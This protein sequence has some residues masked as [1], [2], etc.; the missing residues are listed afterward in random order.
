M[1]KELSS[2]SKV[3][4]LVS[5]FQ[6]NQDVSQR[7]EANPG[8][9][10]HAND[11][12]PKGGLKFFKNSVQIRRTSSQVARF[13]SAKKVF[14]MKDKESSLN[15]S[16]SDAPVSR[17]PIVSPTMS[18][19]LPQKLLSS[20]SKIPIGEFWKDKRERKVNDKGQGHVESNKENVDKVRKTEKVKSKHVKK[21]EVLAKDVGSPGMDS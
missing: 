10:H 18:S 4:A 6:S 21:Y 5:N 7:Q 19:T 20:G 12:T 17:P 8:Q 2:S 13:S 3:A 1:S 15:L 9:G 16:H 14:E 11:S